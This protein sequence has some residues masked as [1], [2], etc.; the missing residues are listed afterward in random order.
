MKAEKEKKNITKSVK[1]SQNQYDIIMQK[2]TEKHMNFS[3]YMVDSAIHGNNSFTPQI[4]VKIQ[5]IANTA[6]DLAERISCDDY[7]AKE[8]LCQQT[9]ELNELF[10][11]ESPLERYANIIKDIE[12]IT[13]GADSLWVYLK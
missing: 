7:A 6:L 3:E 12:K 8:K 9:D 4:A 5:S 10:H 11:T 13:K 1:L 2:A